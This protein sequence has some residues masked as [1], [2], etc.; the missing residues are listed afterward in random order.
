MQQEPPMPDDDETIA[1]DQDTSADASGSASLFSAT[2]ASRIR[3]SS[4]I[5]GAIPGRTPLPASVPPPASQPEEDTPVSRSRPVRPAAPR[6][7]AHLLAGL[8]YLVPPVVPAI[9]L[10]SPAPHRFARFHALQALALFMAA[11]TL[12]FLLSICTPTNLMLGIFYVALVITCV[13]LALLW[14]AAAIA[15]FEGLAVALPVLDRIIPRTTDLE[16]DLNARARAIG[17]RSLLE[18]AIAVVASIVLLALTI[19]L[20]LAGWFGALSPKNLT[21]LGLTNGLPAWMVVSSLL[22]SLIFAVIGLIALAV[23]AQGLRQGKFLPSLASG[24]AVVGAALT[25]AGT[26]LLIAYTTE[27]SLYSKLEQQFQSVVASAPLPQP[28]ASSDAFTQTIMNG[29]SALDT[30]AQAQ[31]ALL[32]PGVALL[33]LGLGILLFLLSQLYYKK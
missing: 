2:R 29:R 23:L 11:M 17:Q 25:A 32:A 1:A 9:I 14:T 15:A 18:A 3:R 16:E 5:S 26:G 28:R 30:I 8:C 33:L 19:A 6:T 20:P 12:G 22:V 7:Y 4:R 27:R 10:F 24:A 13:G 21:P 31:H